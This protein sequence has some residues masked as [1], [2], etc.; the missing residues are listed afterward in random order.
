MGFLHARLV[1]FK[2]NAKF[3]G[4]LTNEFNA[5]L[6]T[7]RTHRPDELN[8]GE[9]FAFRDRFFS[10]FHPSDKGRNPHAAS[11]PELTLCGVFKFRQEGAP[12]TF[13]KN[14][15]SCN[16][17]HNALR[18]NAHILNPEKE[19]VFG[20]IH[21]CDRKGMGVFFVARKREIGKLTSNHLLRHLAFHCQANERMID[22]DFLNHS[23][24]TYIHPDTTAQ[25]ANRSPKPDD[26]DDQVD[27]AQGHDHFRFFK[28]SRTMERQ[29]HIDPSPH[30][31]HTLPRVPL[32]LA[33][34]KTHITPD[35]GE[36]V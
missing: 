18:P 33:L 21:P 30:T 25:D 6:F 4:L 12:R 32:H 35:N 8:R 34:T 19:F 3:G 14:L 17:M 11:H 24:F 27:P 26:R 31:V 36:H 9:L 29:D 5:T 16:L 22:F 13:Y 20:A 7:H 2:G 28:E 23:L 15:V 10:Q 1:N